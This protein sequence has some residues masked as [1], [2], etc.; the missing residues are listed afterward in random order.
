M[1]LRRPTVPADA[2]RPAV[3]LP[4]ADLVAVSHSILS[5][6]ALRDLI[7]RAY[8]ID[9][10]MTCQLLLSGMNDTYLLTTRDQRYIVRVYGT[11]RRSLPEI[12]YELELLTH[13]GAKGVS[14]SVPIAG[15]DG[16]P[17]RPLTAPEGTRQL[18]LFTYAEGTPLSWDKEEHCYLAGRVAAMIHAASDDFV[19]R[20]ARLRVDLEYLVDRPLAAIRP[21]LAQRPDHWRYLE[22][23]AVKLRA[24][25]SVAASTGLEWGVCH[26]DLNNRNIHIAPDSTTTVF[27][28]DLAGLAGGHT[29]SAILWGTMFHPQN[30]VWEPFLKGYTEIRHLAAPDIA[31]VPLFY[32]VTRLASIGLVARNA[33]KSGISFMNDLYFEGQ[34]AFFRK[35]EADYLKKVRLLEPGRT[36]RDGHQQIR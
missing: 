3:R 25:A 36:E 13:L 6:E 31:A 30:D 21:F 11:G 28:F 10:P 8:A 20:H 29:I 24:G 2:E 15:K 1:T 5:A 12:L 27:D 19:T 33:A 4:D 7:A 26:G 22:E 14:V 17:T 32:A 9:T 18:V 16:R 23:L 34:L 35:W